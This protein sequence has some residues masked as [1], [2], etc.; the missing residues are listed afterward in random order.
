MSNQKFPPGWDEKRV[1]EVLAD[2]ESLTEDEQIAFNGG[3][4]LAN[5]YNG[6]RLFQ[7]GIE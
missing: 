1:R 2:Y 6:T 4:T 5:R 3:G 7:G